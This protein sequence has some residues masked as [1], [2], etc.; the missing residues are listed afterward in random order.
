[1]F[2]TERDAKA[3]WWCPFAQTRFFG[4][5]PK[6]PASAAVMNRV[7]PG[8]RQLRLRNA[9]YRTFF[10]RLHWLMRAKYFRCAGSGCGA[11]RWE[12]GRR[13]RGYCGL[14]GKPED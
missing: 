6:S 12:D 5:D 7:R 11:W 10:P 13:L 2:A 1:M 3:T 14:A 4:A 9:L 8:T